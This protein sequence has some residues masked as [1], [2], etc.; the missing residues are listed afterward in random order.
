MVKYCNEYVCVCVC[1]CLACVFICLQTYLPNHTL[2]LYQFLCMFAVAVARSSCVGVTK[3]QGEWA[4]FGVFFPID[5][6]LYS[7]TFGTHTK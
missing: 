1:V 6:A 5:N 7:I 3:S 4:I 2:N